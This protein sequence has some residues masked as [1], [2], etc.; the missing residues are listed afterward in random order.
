M[1]QFFLIKVLYKPSKAAA[2]FPSVFIQVLKRQAIA[3]GLAHFVAALLPNSYTRPTRALKPGDRTG[4]ARG[5]SAGLRN[6]HLVAATWRRQYG[7][8]GLVS[9]SR[10]LFC[11]VKMGGFHQLGGDHQ[12]F[13][14]L[15]I[16]R[17]WGQSRLLIGVRGKVREVIFW[18]QRKPN[19]NIFGR[20]A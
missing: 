18:Q 8:G 4:V 17:R 14:S 12:H 1:K 10:G 20:G 11:E 9:N 6:A 19:D 7:F 13:Q 3:A 16:M 2:V 15:P 5:H